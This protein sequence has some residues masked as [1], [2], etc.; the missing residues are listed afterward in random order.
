M[1]M[2]WLVYVALFL[3]FSELLALLLAVTNF[4]FSLKKS[5]R[6][7]HFYT[8][9][10]VLII[11]CKWLDENFEQNISSFYRQDYDDYLMWFVV[12]SRDDPVYEPLC[13]MRD[14]LLKETKAK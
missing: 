2:D 12:E 11:P 5:G 13:K 8:P 4:W 9:R 14:R 6:Q 10:T 3:I 1:A 7:R